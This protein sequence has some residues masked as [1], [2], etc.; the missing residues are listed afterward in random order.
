MMN[1][2]RV[3]KNE[4]GRDLFPIISCRAIRRGN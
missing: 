1:A 3:G 4:Y 2:D